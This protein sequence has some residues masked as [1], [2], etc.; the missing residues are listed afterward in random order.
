M[1]IL[2]VF[3]SKDYSKILWTRRFYKSRFTTTTPYAE[4]IQTLSHAKTKIDRFSELLSTLSSIFFFLVASSTKGNKGNYKTGSE[5]AESANFPGKLLGVQKRQG[6]E[7][8][9]SDSTDKLWFQMA[10]ERLSKSRNGHGWHQRQVGT[11]H[12]WDF[13]KLIVPVLYW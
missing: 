1:E 2:S 13:H 9:C 4:P 12:F 7:N 5:F 3:F 10:Q 11:Q 6:I 8:H